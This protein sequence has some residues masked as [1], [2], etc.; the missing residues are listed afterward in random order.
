M[1]SRASLR[2]HPLIRSLSYRVCLWRMAAITA[3]VNA[4]VSSARPADV[5]PMRPLPRTDAYAA[6][7]RASSAGQ[8]GK[9]ARIDSAMR[10]ASSR[11]C[12]T[13]RTASR[14]RLD[15]SLSSVRVAFFFRLNK[16]YLFDQ[17]PL[18]SYRRRALLKRTT[19][20]DRVLRFLARRVRAV[21]P[22]GR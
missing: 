19:T 16:R 4:S 3:A 6:I 22:L 21:S 1:A 7:A 13:P 17:Y 2:L 15:S 10:V 14:S 8:P 11:T 12:S 5:H 18:A 20:A 9:R